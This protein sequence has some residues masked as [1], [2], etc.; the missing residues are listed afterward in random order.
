MSAASLPVLPCFQ[1]KDSTPQCGRRLLHCRISIGLMTA[2]GQTQPSRDVRE[3]SVLPSISAVMSQSRDRQLRA[4]SGPS[5]CNNIDRFPQ[6]K[7]CDQFIHSA[8]DSHGQRFHASPHVYFAHRKSTHFD[9]GSG[10]D[11]VG[12]NELTTII[13]GQVLE[14]SSHM[15]RIADCCQEK[16]IPVAKLAQDH[17]AG[18]EADAD[19]NWL[20]QFVSQCSIHV[21]ETAMNKLRR[22]QCLRAS[23]MRASMYAKDRHHAVADELVGH[24]ACVDYR[25]CH[26]IEEMIQ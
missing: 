10:S 20:R 5:R 12:H 14:T 9:A 23:L 1:P 2:V 24:A 7:S 13:F 18:V 3:M 25:A 21:G 17:V 15:Y 6:G 22:N 8:D 16:A 4:K 11:D 19:C 26:G